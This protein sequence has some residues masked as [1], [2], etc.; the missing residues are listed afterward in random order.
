MDDWAVEVGF[1][2]ICNARFNISIEKVKMRTLVLGLSDGFANISVCH[3]N[4]LSLV[5]KHFHQLA[6]HKATSGKRKAIDTHLNLLLETNSGLVENGFF[7]K[8]PIVSGD[9]GIPKKAT[10]VVDLQILCNKSCGDTHCLNL[11]LCIANREA[12]GT[13]FLKL[14]VLAMVEPEKSHLGVLVVPNRKYFEQSNMDPGY[15]DDGEYNIA[16]K[17]AYHNVFESEMALISL[18][19]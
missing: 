18:G 15:G 10:H 7:A 14:E 8:G 9:S 2:S 17:L 11:Q 16:Y 13:N 6:Q 12:L 1:Q 5:E 4:M 3:S 19:D